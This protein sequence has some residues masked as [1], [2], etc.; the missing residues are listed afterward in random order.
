MNG[1]DLLAAQ[2]TQEPSPEPQYEITNPLAL[3]LLYGPTLTF[4]HDYWKNHSFDYTDLCQPN[5][6]SLF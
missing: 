2:G 4:V 3:N 5:V 1:L 6:V